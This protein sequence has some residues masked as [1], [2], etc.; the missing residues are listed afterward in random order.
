MQH[1]ITLVA[2]LP[3]SCPDAAACEY[4]AKDHPESCRHEF[5]PK[6]TKTSFK[7]ANRFNELVSH[8]G[9]SLF[10]DV[11]VKSFEA[12]ES[13]R[14]GRSGLQQ[15]IGRILKEI[16]QLITGD[17]HVDFAEAVS[18]T[19][20][21]TQHRELIQSM[22]SAGR[23]TNDALAQLETDNNATGGGTYK[24][25]AS[26]QRELCAVCKAFGQEVLVREFDLQQEAFDGKERSQ[27]GRLSRIKFEAH[28]AES[29]TDWVDQAY[30]MEI[31]KRAKRRLQDHGIKT[32]KGFALWKL[33]VHSAICAAKPTRKSSAPG[34]AITLPKIADVLER[35]F[36]RQLSLRRWYSAADGAVDSASDPEVNWVMC[37]LCKKWRKIEDAAYFTQV[38]GNTTWHCSIEGSPY[39][40]ADADSKTGCAIPAEDPADDDIAA[41][42]TPLP[43]E[44]VLKPAG[45]ATAAITAIS[46]SAVAKKLP[47]DLPAAKQSQNSDN[48][49]L[50]DTMMHVQPGKG[51]CPTC[52]ALH[53]A[54]VIDAGSVGRFSV[55]RSPRHKREG[56][57]PY[58]LLNTLLGFWPGGL[59]PSKKQQQGGLWQ[60]LQKSYS[61]PVTSRN[62]HM[63][64]LKK[65]FGIFRKGRNSQHGGKGSFSAQALRAMRP[66]VLRFRQD[67]KDI[68]QHYSAETGTTRKWALQHIQKADEVLSLPEPQDADKDTGNEPPV[69]QRRRSRRLS[70][71]G[72]D[73][74]SG[75]LCRFFS[76]PQGC[77]KGDTCDMCHDSGETTEARA[78]SAVAPVAVRGAGIQD[79]AKATGKK[80]KF[81][82]SPQ[83]CKKGDTCDM[84]HDSGNAGNQGSAKATRKRKQNESLT[85]LTPTGRSSTKKRKQMDTNVGGVKDSSPEPS[86]APMSRGRSKSNP[87]VLDSSESDSESVT[88]P[89]TRRSP[90]PSPKRRK[91]TQPPQLLQSPSMVQWEFVL[92]LVGKNVRMRQHLGRE[93]HHL[94]PL[95]DAGL[96]PNKDAV[97]EPV[98]W[99]CRDLITRQM[100]WTFIH[101]Y[102]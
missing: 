1:G 43:K 71:D 100:L 6:D 93:D 70:E 58:H 72:S 17:M 12:Y 59:T 98:K 5:I 24:D 67:I 48:V 40:K 63:A 19:L 33:N 81:F 53:A 18:V 82:S 56:D 25:F 21:Q 15:K 27:I 102:E 31:C 32:E 2:E 68:P 90:H 36:W 80:C 38:S 16:R 65:I 75:A 83:G 50:Y 69:L 61:I 51:S 66:L 4:R 13:R 28:F 46:A 86:R 35:V 22:I 87:V 11:F 57:C 30:R 99:K 10:R 3:S 97:I 49:S 34:F 52:A 76:S 92:K 41:K 96:L 45:T 101:S 39:S 62:I 20:T 9:K 26:F 29:W 44:V 37:F 54:K 74:K 88:S 64:Q 7:E 77:K 47:E 73:K 84:R 79:S 89:Q 8:S 78:A 60:M 55:T 95:R 14:L 23:G 94:K 91:R 42:S 85:H